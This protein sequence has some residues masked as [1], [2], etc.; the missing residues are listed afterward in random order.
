MLTNAPNLLGP[1]L[2]EHRRRK[3]YELF[4]ELFVGHWLH[5]M[6]RRIVT[7]PLEH[8]PVPQSQN[9]SAGVLLEHQ[10]MRARFAFLFPLRFHRRIGHDFNQLA[11]E[12]R[13]FLITQSVCRELARRDSALEYRR[14][15]TK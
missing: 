11:G 6:P 15:N 9:D 5:G 4:I 12:A 10:S 2:R 8:P 14:G 7:A 3:P 13:Q 1:V